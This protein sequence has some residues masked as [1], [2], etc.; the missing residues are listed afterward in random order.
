MPL[1]DM[2]DML[3]HAYDHSYAVGAFEV[4]SLDFLEGIMQAAEQARAPVILSLAESHFAC[5]DFDLLMPAVEAAAQRAQVPVALHFDHGSCIESAIK[6]INSGC[7]GILVDAS[8]KDFIENSRITREVVEMARRC[9]VSVEGE[10]GYV[11]GVE[12]E[13][14][15]D[16]PGEPAYTSV[17]EAKAYVERTG[18]DF[19][20]VSIGTVHGHMKGKPRLDYNRL[21]QINTALQIPLVIHGGSGL[22]DDQYRRLIGAGITKI[23]CYTALSD[24]AGSALRESDSTELSY[25]RQQ[26][27]VREAIAAETERL[28]RLWGAAGRAAEVLTQCQQWKPVEHLLICNAEGDSHSVAALMTTAREQLSAIPGV[29]EVFTG[30]AIQHEARY[31]YTCLLQFCHPEVLRH[32]QDHPAYTHFVNELLKPAAGSCINIDF[33]TLDIPGHSISA[34]LKAARLSSIA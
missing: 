24:T 22:S 26:K 6:G 34:A 25:G 9:G 8:D 29:R 7:N 4:I 28:M 3:R 13:G 16:Y 5:F 19:L 15:E 27:I 2:K 31:Q 20:A 33:K 12:G 10:L 21:K 18:V 14:A 23:N 1:V 32:Y 17:A 11:P 30:E